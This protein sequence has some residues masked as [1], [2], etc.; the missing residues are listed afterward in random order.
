LPELASIPF[1]M[2]GDVTETV[3]QIIKGNG[4]ELSWAP[5]NRA[6]W[7]LSPRPDAPCAAG[8]GRAQ[9][10]QEGVDRRVEAR[11]RRRHRA[12]SLSTRRKAPQSQGLSV[13]ETCI[14]A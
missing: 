12:S 11:S 9:V 7:R 10:G 3:D 14:C 4:E 13:D 5:T 8:E 6:S 2:E 1:G